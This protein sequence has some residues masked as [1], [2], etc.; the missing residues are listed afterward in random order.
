[1]HQR[2]N[3]ALFCVVKP[4]LRITRSR[5]D[6]TDAETHAVHHLDDDRHVRSAR[7]DGERQHEGE[8]VRLQ[9]RVRESGRPPQHGGDATVE[10]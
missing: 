8:R 3:D 4:P 6:V 1:M 7:R 10:R 2:H 5:I 9:R